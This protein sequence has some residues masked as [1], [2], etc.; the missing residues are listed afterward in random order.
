MCI[1]FVFAPTD[2]YLLYDIYHFNGGRPLSNTALG[3]P[4]ELRGIIADIIRHTMSSMSIRDQSCI[5]IIQT[6]TDT[7]LH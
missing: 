7:H 5:R 1:C 3:A 2:I 4:G 6:N